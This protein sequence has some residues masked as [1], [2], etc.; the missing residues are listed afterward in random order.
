MRKYYLDNIRWMTVLAVVLYH[1]IFMYNHILT[2]GVVGPVTAFGGQD[3]VQYLL[4]PWFMVVLF[5]VSGACARY[6]LERRGAKAFFAERTRKLL[7]PS[8]LGLLVLGWAQGYFNMAFS[9]AFEN[10]PAGVPAPVL[11]LIMVVSGTGVL[12]T[13]HVLWLCSVLLLA[14]RRLERG[15]LLRFCAGTPFWA[16]V[17]LGAAVW[18]SAQV[19]NAPH[20]VVYRF[21]IYLFS[22]LLGYYV[23]SQ[24]TV[25]DALSRRAPALLMA[26]VLLGAVYLWRS[27]GENYA[28]AP[29]MNSPLAIAY[30]WAACLTVF[31]AMKRWGDRT[32]PF[33][34]FMTR[35]SFGLYV[36]HYLALSAAAYGL[37]FCLHLRGARVYLLSAAAAFGG[38]LA[39]YAVLRRVPV[40]RF[41]V[42][43]IRK[44]K[45]HVL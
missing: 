15:R 13:C 43:G 31:G 5:L 7:V 26:A 33:A 19:L 36:C 24:G 32:G 18:A 25:V 28:A 39:L 22:Y 23:F 34:A 30:A 29:N 42:F 8:T 4:Y 27:W 40:V 16:V 17:L 20:I 45:D 37:V 41:C 9:H 1:V 10:I 44:E 35:H 21:G 38:G 11:Y 12:W 14:V 2:A 6:A 3:A